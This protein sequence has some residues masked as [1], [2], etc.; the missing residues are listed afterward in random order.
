MSV[1]PGAC[2]SICVIR[3]TRTQLSGPRR[4]S[5]RGVPPSIGAG[6]RGD[7]GA[8]AE[9]RI[10]FPIITLSWRKWRAGG[11]WWRL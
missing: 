5:A 10:V 7:E 9:N 6:W 11:T 4:A 3:I 1:R 8:R 2:D